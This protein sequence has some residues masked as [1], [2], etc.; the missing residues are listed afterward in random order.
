QC[1]VGPRADDAY[2]D[3][4]IPT[5][6]PIETVNPVADIEIVAR[7]LAV[8]GKA[9]GCDRNINR[10][11]PDVSFGV[12]M[13][14]NPLVLRRAAGFGSGVGNQRAIFGDASVLLVADGVLVERAG[15]QIAVDFG[16]RNAVVLKVERRSHKQI[17]LFCLFFYIKSL[18]FSSPVI[19]RSKLS[20]VAAWAEINQFTTS[21][22][23][24]MP[25]R[26][27][28]SRTGRWR[29]RFSV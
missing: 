18:L 20:I 28:P 4:M 2:F 27:A 21:P 13:L 11:P 1:V 6:E 7:S 9:L 14:Y 10:A 8:D 23:E 16:H 19:Y 17:S 24:R 12:G 25:T 22:I 15:R 3:R 29:T 26:S 5:R